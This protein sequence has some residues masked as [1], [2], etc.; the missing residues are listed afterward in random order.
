M[1]RYAAVK[2][3][4]NALRTKNYIILFKKLGQIQSNILYSF[5]YR[6][7]RFVRLFVSRPTYSRDVY[8]GREARYGYIYYLILS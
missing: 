2:K 1:F 3:K 8:P 5:R 6:N 4:K 7:N